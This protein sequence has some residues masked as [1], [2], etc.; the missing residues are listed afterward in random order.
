MIHSGTYGTKFQRPAY[1]QA[2]IKFTNPDFTSQFKETDALIDSGS[3]VTFVP[4]S[5]AE[6]LGIIPSNYKPVADF[7]KQTKDN[8]AVYP[9]IVTLGN[10]EELMEVYET[11]AYAIIG[12]DVLNRY[13]TLLQGKQQK[14][15]IE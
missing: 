4:K 14:W 13:K 5:I 3:S 6:D 7:E 1:P 2:K 8:R 15:E 9:I 10:F 12:R 11:H